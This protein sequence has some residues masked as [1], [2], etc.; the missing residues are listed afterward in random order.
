[1][2]Y[3]FAGEVVDVENL[4]ERGKK[5]GR[6]NLTPWPPSRRGKGEE[7]KGEEGRG[8]RRASRRG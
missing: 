5:A 4:L 1:M 3:R 8:R 7:G 6:P 2:V